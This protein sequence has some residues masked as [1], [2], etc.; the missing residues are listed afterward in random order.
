MLNAST[1]VLMCKNAIGFMDC[2][3]DLTVLDS[4]I[5]SDKFGKMTSNSSNILIFNRLSS[6]LLS[7]LET[8]EIENFSVQNIADMLTSE[9]SANSS[10][11]LFKMIKSQKGG[12][13]A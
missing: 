2:K 12:L 13:T 7:E 5:K 8:L 3:D 10:G 9:N 6:E 4:L 1:K 11:S